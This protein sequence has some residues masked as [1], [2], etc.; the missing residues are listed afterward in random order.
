MDEESME[1]SPDDFIV[2]INK[3]DEIPR[4]KDDATKSPTLTGESSS[5]GSTPR[6]KLPPKKP[7]RKRRGESS[8]YERN[9]DE[10]EDEKEKERIKRAI[11]SKDNRVKKKKRVQD[12]ETQVQYWQTQVQDRETQLQD[13]NSRYQH[14]ET[15]LRESGKI[16]VIEISIPQM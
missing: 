2:N 1:F 10:Y 14:L 13:L 3:H 15:E 5:T 8:I 6:A 4:D 9:P 7:G 11:T 16:C 12:L